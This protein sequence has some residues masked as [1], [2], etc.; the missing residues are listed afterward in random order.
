[1]LQSRKTAENGLEILLKQ[2][3]I[4]GL[5]FDLDGVVTQTAKLHATAWKKMFDEFLQNA[6]GIASKSQLPF[7]IENDYPRYLDGISRIEGIRNFLHSRQL[8]I[9][10]VNYL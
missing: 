5:L 7:S 1:M 6:T 8:C 4:R 2:R 10:L 9:I 3:N